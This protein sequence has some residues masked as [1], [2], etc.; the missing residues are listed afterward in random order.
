M[1][2]ILSKITNKQH[3]QQQAGWQIFG[4]LENLP[5]KNYG[6]ESEFSPFQN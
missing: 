5:I 4:M 6:L 3:Q 1:K 2:K